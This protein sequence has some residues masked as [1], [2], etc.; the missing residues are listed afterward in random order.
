[1]GE[2]DEPTQGMLNFTRA[3]LARHMDDERAKN[4]SDDEVG[5]IVP[6]VLD[7]LG[8]LR[9]RDINVIILR[10]GLYGREPLSYE[11]V[12]IQVGKE[13][14][15]T[16]ERVRQITAHTIRTLSRTIRYMSPEEY[17]L[18]ALL[19]GKKG[20]TPVLNDTTRP[21]ITGDLE[22]IIGD[23]KKIQFKYNIGQFI[24]EKF[25]QSLDEQTPE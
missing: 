10:Y 12:G 22:C 19:A 18:Y 11:K 24:F 3:L 4:L 9:E 5:W 15:L 13:K 21:K 7:E 2:T 6:L 1:M 17:N 14:P 16:R 23:L 20:A 8:K 25:K